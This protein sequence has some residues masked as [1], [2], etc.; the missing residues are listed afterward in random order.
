[1]SVPETTPVEDLEALVALLAAGLSAAKEK[2]EVEDD[3]DS[4]D[5]DDDSEEE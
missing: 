5:D 2:A 1:M 4:D 3:E